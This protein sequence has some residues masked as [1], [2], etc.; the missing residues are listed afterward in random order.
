MLTR[1]VIVPIAP[2]RLYELLGL[3]GNLADDTCQGI[4]LQAS[5]TNT[6]TV[7]FGDRGQQVQELEAGAS[8]YPSVNSAKNIWVR[9][10]NGT[11][12]LNVTQ[13]IGP[14]G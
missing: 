11:D 4:G 10:D 6:G 13:T 5:G 12:L 8:S 2:T 7:Y 1:Q 9:S 3:P 14:A